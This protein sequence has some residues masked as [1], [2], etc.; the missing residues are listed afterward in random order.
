LTSLTLEDEQ[1]LLSESFRELGMGQHRIGMVGHIPCGGSGILEIG[2]IGKDQIETLW[3][4]IEIQELRGIHLLDASSGTFE[5]GGLEIFTDQSRSWAMV[6]HEDGGCGTPAQGLDTECS[7]SRIEI[8]DAGPWHPF[9][10]RGEDGAAYPVH[11]RSG[12]L[13]G[14]LK[15]ESACGSGNHAHGELW[16]RSSL[17]WSGRGL[18]GCRLIRFWRGGAPEEP[19]KYPSKITADTDPGEALHQIGFR[20]GGRARD[21]ERNLRVA[22]FG[23]NGKFLAE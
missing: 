17:P 23:S 18:R 15:G 21:M 6:F 16:G 13:A 14:W 1:S 4:R 2:W 7:A 19:L 11:S 20:V 9:T 22:R 12:S 3:G 5:P 10:K 8:Q